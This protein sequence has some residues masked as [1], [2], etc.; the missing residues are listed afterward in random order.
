MAKE[1]A[2]RF[3]NSKEWYKC[4]SSYIKSVHG[5][6]E[7]CDK[8]GYIVHHKKTLTPNNINDSNVTLNHDNLEYLCLDCHNAEHDFNRDKKRA[9]K[10]EYKFNDK[11]ELIPV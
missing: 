11:G 3:Y 4:K 9:T 8:P 10:K 5:L 6:C 1:F 2:K 7:R